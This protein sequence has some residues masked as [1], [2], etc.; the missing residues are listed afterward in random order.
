[1]RKFGTFLIF[2]VPE[3]NVGSLPFGKCY[4]RPRLNYLPTN[5]V[6]SMSSPMCCT[7]LLSRRLPICWHAVLLPSR[8]QEDFQRATIAIV[9]EVALSNWR[10]LLTCQYCSL[11]PVVEEATAQSC[12]C[13]L[14]AVKNLRRLLTPCHHHC[15]GGCAARSKEIADA[16]PSSLSRRLR[17]QIEGDCWCTNIAVLPP[18]LRRF[19]HYSLAAVKNLR[20]TKDVG[21][22]GNNQSNR[23]IFGTNT[24]GSQ[25]RINRESTDRGSANG[26]AW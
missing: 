22:V 8:I 13:S 1:M 4:N 12:H 19:P 18:L 14:A 26:E 20:R 5:D 3:P 6:E 24:R 2:L 23:Q 16:P 7:P 17:C 15:Q 11:A 25:T 21:G 9:K 10:I